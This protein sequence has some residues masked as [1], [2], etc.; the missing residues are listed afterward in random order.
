MRLMIDTC[1]AELD[2]GIRFMESTAEIRRTLTS[3][4]QGDRLADITADDVVV[5]PVIHGV[6]HPN[7]SGLKKKVVQDEPRA[8]YMYDKD[9]PVRIED[10]ENAETGD[11]PLVHPAVMERF[12]KIGGYRPPALRGRMFRLFDGRD[13]RTTIDGNS[14]A[15]RRGREALF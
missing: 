12:S 7:I 10:R 6:L 11:I 1:S 9:R 2:S 15:V 5:R 4:A 14:R 13:N 8:V 3:D